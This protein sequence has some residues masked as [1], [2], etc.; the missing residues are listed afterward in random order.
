MSA[1]PNDVTEVSI[2]PVNPSFFRVIGAITEEFGVLSAGSVMTGVGDV[3][4][5]PLRDKRKAQEAA[6]EVNAMFPLK[7]RIVDIK[8]AKEKNLLYADKMAAVEGSE[9]A[10]RAAAASIAATVTKAHV[11]G[12]GAA[13]PQGTAIAAGAPKEGVSS[14]STSSAPASAAAPGDEHFCV[15]VNLQEQSL[16]DVLTAVEGVFAECKKTLLRFEEELTW[17]LLKKVH[18][19]L[20]TDACPEEAKKAYND[21]MDSEITTP[22]SAAVQQYYRFFDKLN[23]LDIESISV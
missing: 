13:H 12:N 18:G 8:G 19:L 1:A 15:L 5:V 4:S 14:S 17:T 10:K 6:T 9:D 3:Y 21:L 7:R 22:F 11:A 20:N 16:D 2:S 23:D